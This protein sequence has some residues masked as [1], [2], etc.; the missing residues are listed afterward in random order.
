MILGL[1]ESI[2]KLIAYLIKQNIHG[3][4]KVLEIKFIITLSKILTDRTKRVLK[5][6]NDSFKS[7]IE[8][9]DSKEAG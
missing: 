7:F 8:L 3:L 2:T 5:D 6:V 1:D 4:G 9:L